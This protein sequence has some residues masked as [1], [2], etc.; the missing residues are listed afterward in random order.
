MIALFR[1]E[2][3][4][5]R[6]F[7]QPLSA[8]SFRVR[9]LTDVTAFTGVGEGVTCQEVKSSFLKARS[10]VTSLTQRL[11]SLSDPLG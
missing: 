3:R 10:C 8:Q 2:T 5:V 11:Q 6:W 4:L 1:R 7:L 9:V